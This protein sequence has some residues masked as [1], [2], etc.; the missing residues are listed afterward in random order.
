MKMPASVVQHIGVKHL[1]WTT[2]ACSP[3]TSAC[4]FKQLVQSVQDSPQ[5]YSTSIF[6]LLLTE[7]LNRM[8]AIVLVVCSV[9]AATLAIPF[10][11]NKLNKEK[12]TL[13]EIE[14]K[15]R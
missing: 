10:A 4:V 3:H 9:I 8:K 11:D 7:L 5:T 1:F 13:A 12:S 15:L 2:Q 6:H 14:E